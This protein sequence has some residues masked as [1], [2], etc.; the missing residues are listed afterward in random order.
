MKLYRLLVEALDSLYGNKLRSILTVLGI[1][2]GVAAV[3]AMLSIG[4]GAEA[5]I[6]SRIE[7][8]GTNLV[9]I[10]PG[11]TSQGGV[12][13]AAGSAGTL[14]LDDSTALAD[15]PNVVAVAPV[16]NSFV[17]VVYQGQN[18]N[19]RLVGV[20]PG[21]E[22]VSSLTLADGE[23][24]A[25]SD[26]NARSL[27]VV[28]G[29]SVAQNLFG[30][31]GGV[32]G[33]KV[34]LNGQP[35]KVVGVLVSKGSTGFMNQDDQVFIPLST[36]LN[37]LVGGS[38]F[39]GSSVISQITV[40][41]ASANVVDQVVEDVTLTMRTR[42]ETVEGADDFTVASQEAT[43]EAAT[44]VSDTLTI[45]LGGIAGISLMVGG[46]GIMNIMLT[47]VTERTHEIGLRKAVGAKRKDILLQFLV[48]STVLSLTGGLIGVAFGWGTARLLGQV[49][50]GGSS[51]TPVVS[52][53]SILLAALFSMVVGLFFGIYPATRA[54]RLQPVE[55]L[56][57]E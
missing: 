25:E 39:R 30:G 56:R 38:R 9:Y 42:H 40:K 27:V 16:T 47:T 52:L 21:Y 57:Y 19:T 2:I 45:F 31:T 14:T 8:M 5:S 28:L 37:R 46:I 50:I 4:R 34:R 6:T 29:S 17:Q 53:D 3:I 32:V 48:E 13:S 11:S 26:Q 7:G 18:L 1:V 41:A 44:E 22:T 23:F 49:Q 33:Q 51:I 36:A 12:Q 55:A 20:T 54:A 15:L 43:L 35:Y 24:I 10:T